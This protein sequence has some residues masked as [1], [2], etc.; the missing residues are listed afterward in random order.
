MTIWNDVH[1][2]PGIEFNHETGE[3][4]RKAGPATFVFTCTDINRGTTWSY[5]MFNIGDLADAEA[6]AARVR[7]SEARQG[8][9]VTV[10]VAEVGR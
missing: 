10:T 6:V 3:Y 8:R 2:C 5:T 7:R 4:R 1:D 9:V